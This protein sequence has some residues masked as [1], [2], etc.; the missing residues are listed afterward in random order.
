[1]GPSNALTPGSGVSPNGVS[2]DG[3]SFKGVS[4]NVRLIDTMS[5]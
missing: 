5:P 4:P 2:S 1:M 3:V